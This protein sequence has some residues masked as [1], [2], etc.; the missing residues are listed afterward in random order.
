MLVA[1]YYIDYYNIANFIF[2]L[3][4]YCDQSTVHNASNYKLETNS[5]CSYWW[6]IQIYLHVLWTCFP[7]DIE[8]F[9]GLDSLPCY[10]VTLTDPTDES[11]AKGR[12][13][14][15]RAMR[16]QLVANKRVK[17]LTTRDPANDETI[18]VVGGGRTVVGTVILVC[19]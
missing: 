1:N 10:T 19:I 8:D 13:V 17:E 9:P 11:D 14:H 3:L 7:G 5:S 6:Y 4:V 18:V 16:S 2:I 12:G 15:V